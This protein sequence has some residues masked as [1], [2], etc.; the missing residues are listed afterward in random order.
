MEHIKFSRINCRI[1]Q[2]RQQCPLEETEQNDTRDF[3]VNYRSRPST[4]LVSIH[5]KLFEKIVTWMRKQEFKCHLS[6]ASTIKH[7]KVEEWKRVFLREGS[8]ETNFKYDKRAWIRWRWWWK[9]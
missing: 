9:G 6:F 1:H 7:V 3:V 4:E 2:K 5:L 8:K